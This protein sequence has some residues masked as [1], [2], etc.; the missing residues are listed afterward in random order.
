MGRPKGDPNR[1]S[2]MEDRGGTGAGRF[3]VRIYVDGV[4]SFRTFATRE[5][6]D[7][8]ATTYRREGAVRTDVARARRLMTACAPL[9]ENAA[10]Y[11]YCIKAGSTFKIGYAKKP[12]Q[13]LI[14][15]QTGSAT[16]LEMMAMRPGG[17]DAETAMHAALDKFWLRGEWFRLNPESLA[18]VRALFG[19]ERM[20]EL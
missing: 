12:R 7:G 6:A 3:R 1:V 17:E 18:V 13:R 8:F 9:E 14:S 4:M 20:Y 10:T 16:K 11:V 5:E 19:P 2:C 15:M